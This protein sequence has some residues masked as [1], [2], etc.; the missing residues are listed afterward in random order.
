MNLVGKIF[1]FLIFCMSVVFMSFAVMIYATHK[2]WRDEVLRQDVGP[3]GE[4]IGWKKRLEDEKRKNVELQAQ[5]E[6]L[7]NQIATQEAAKRQEIAKLEAEYGRLQDE[8]TQ[9]KDTY[10][11]KTRELSDLLAKVQAQQDVL[12]ALREE[13]EQMRVDIATTR[14][15]IDEQLEKYLIQT[16]QLHQAQGELKRLEERKGQLLEELALAERVLQANDLTKNT[17][18]DDTPPPI[19]GVITA[20]KR[21][22]DNIYVEVTVGSDDGIRQGNKMEVYRG[23]QYLGQIEIVR[24]A[25][26]KSVGRI[27]RSRQQGEIR[28][29]DRVETRRNLKFTADLSS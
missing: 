22:K 17:P 1:V 8:N 7:Q 14:G 21:M 16:E 25:P 26:D 15:V 18:V 9:L 10:V 3:R 19:D 29:R 6:N 12:E 4:K 23:G 27:D 28:A 20:V 13:N 5:K 11:E 24:T 2:N